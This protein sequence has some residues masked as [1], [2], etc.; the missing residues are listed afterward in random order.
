MLLKLLKKTL[1]DQFSSPGSSYSNK[2]N[3]TFIRKTR[4]MGGLSSARL[5]SK[6]S[7]MTYLD[8]TK[9][10]LQQCCKGQVKF[11]DPTRNVNNPMILTR[12]QE[13]TKI[14]VR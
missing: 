11:P 2:I 7:V 14:Q 12:A 13:G 3:P 8:T 5:K 1:T 9:N 6:Y 4:K 10:S